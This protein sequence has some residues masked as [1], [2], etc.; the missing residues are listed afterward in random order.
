VNQQGT[1]Q[2]AALNQ[3]GTVNSVVSPAAAGT[4]IVLYGTGEGEITS[5]RPNRALTVSV[6]LPSI[7]ANVAVTIGGQNATV[8]YAGAAPFWLP[9][10]FN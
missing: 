2:A 7:V 10:H 6:P 9:A 3:D 8:S 5:S 1:G 4:Y